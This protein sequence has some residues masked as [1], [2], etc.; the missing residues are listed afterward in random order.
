MEQ[1][2]VGV[3]DSFAGFFVRLECPDTSFGRAAESDP[4]ASRHHVNSEFT[5]IVRTDSANRLIVDLR[6][7]DEVCE[8]SFERD[9]ILV[10]EDRKRTESGAVHNDGFT[11]RHQVARRIEFADDDMTAPEKKIAN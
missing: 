7:G 10:T 1:L 4:V 6:L 11:Q 5:G 3:D 8:L 9:E 2:D